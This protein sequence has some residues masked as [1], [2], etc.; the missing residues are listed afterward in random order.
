MNT[1]ISQ[2]RD[3]QGS[4]APKRKDGNG[5][6]SSGGGDCGGEGDGGGICCGE[7]RGNGG[8]DYDDDDDDDKDNDNNDNDDDDD[9]DNDSCRDV[10]R[11]CGDGDS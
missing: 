2:K 11:G 1:T 10:S 8:D 5:S 7:V 6:E 9:D 3:A 4:K